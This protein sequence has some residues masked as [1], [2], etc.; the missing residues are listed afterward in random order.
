MTKLLA[1][2][3]LELNQQVYFLFDFATVLEKRGGMSKV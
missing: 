2:S 3:T 1:F